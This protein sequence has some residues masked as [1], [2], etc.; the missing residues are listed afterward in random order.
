[1]THQ[2]AWKIG[3]ALELL[4][5]LLAAVVGASDGHWAAWICLL[6]AF[7]AFIYVMVKWH[8]CPQCGKS[9]GMKRYPHCPSCGQKLYDRLW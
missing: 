9:L 1:M 8:V 3:I 4:I 7:A 5:F 6:G 2:K